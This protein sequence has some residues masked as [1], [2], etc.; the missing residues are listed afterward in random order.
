MYNAEAA[1]PA[2]QEQ[3]LLPILASGE[4][5]IRITEKQVGP[6][7]QGYRTMF[8]T[9]RLVDPEICMQVFYNKGESF[10]AEERGL[11]LPSWGKSRRM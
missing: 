1:K 11:A 8:E 10:C 7:L 3:V 6:V 5:V 2:L 9:V 4:N